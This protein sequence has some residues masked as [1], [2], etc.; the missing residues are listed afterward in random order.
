MGALGILT[1]TSILLS[2]SIYLFR[3]RLSSKWLDASCLTH[4]VTLS[5][6]PI[7]ITGGNTGLGFE[8][9]LDLARRGGHVVLACRDTISGGRA[10]NNIRIVTKNDNVSC[11]ECNL[12]SLDS[13]RKFAGQVKEKHNGVSAL[14]CN[15]GVWMP[16]NLHAKTD[17]GY[18]VHFGVNH[19]AHFLLIQELMPLLKKSDSRVVLVS[20]S[21]SKSGV[22]DMNTK[23]FLREG[24]QQPEKG[25]AP[26]GYCDSK[27][28]NALTARHLAKQL[29][30]TSV[31]AYSVCPGFCQSRLGRYI[32]V[33]FYKK[34]LVGPMMRLFQRSTQRGAQNIVFAS[35]M[36]KEIL[37][38]GGFYQD[39]KVNEEILK[40]HEKVEKELWDLSM[41]L[42]KEK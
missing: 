12:A 33:P 38:N 5:K 27:L 16:M 21:L 30:G 15:A 32:E 18:E 40:A 34:L 3:R 10:V 17:D 28:M 37:A 35:V 20:S 24:R 8:T 13:V 7:I 23:N 39:G 14:I 1:T 25:F 22:I 31:T 36:K 6:E 19:L 29:D 41:E 26:S 42:I 2:T 4:P 9:A 11:M